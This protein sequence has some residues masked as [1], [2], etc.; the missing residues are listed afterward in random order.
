[1][2]IR[3]AGMLAVVVS[4]VGV[5]FGSSA[6]AVEPTWLTEDSFGTTALQESTLQAPLDTEKVAESLAE[7]EADHQD[8]ISTPGAILERENSTDLF[9]GLGA[10][11]AAALFLDRFRIN[12]Q[13]LTSLPSDPVV[14]AD[15]I[16]EVNTDSS[17]SI[18]PQGPRKASLV[19]SDA[20]LRNESNELLNNSLSV[21]S[22]RFVPQAALT[23]TEIP[24][25]S[26]GQVEF[27]EAGLRM[28][29]GVEAGDGTSGEILSS[30]PGEDDIV[31]Y[32]NT[33]KDTDTAV[34]AT[35][36]GVETFSVLRSEESPETLTFDYEMPEGATLSATDDGGAV[37]TDGEEE[38]LAQIFPPYAVDAQG[39]FVPVTLSVED[40]S[41]GLNVAH[42][43]ADLA[44]PILVD[45]VMH[46][47][48]WWTNGTSADYLGWTF[49]QQGTT[50]Y[51]GS[52]VCPPAVL[53]ADP[54]GGT[55][56][57]LYTSAQP[58]VTYPSGSMG[59]WAFTAPGGPS[60]SILAASIGSWRLRTGPATSGNPYAFF[61]LGNTGTNMVANTAGGGSNYGLTGSAND[62]KVLN[63]G[64]ATNANVTLPS[65][66]TNWRYN[67]LA[68]F[69][70]ELTD[71]EAPTINMTAP[72][73]WLKDNTAYSVTANAADPGL[74]LGWIQTAPFGGSW[75][76]Q[77]A[78]WCSGT[79]GAECPKTASHTMSFNT[80]T[81]TSG[82]N[83]MF[84]KA[85]DVLAGTGHETTVGYN[86]KV[87]KVAPTMATS[88]LLVDTSNPLVPASTVVEVDATDTH[89]G[90]DRAVLKVDGVV[91]GETDVPCETD[92]C[93]M[94][95]EKLEFDGTSLTSG[96]HNYQIIT[97]D[98]A[99]NPSTAKSGTF[100]LDNTSPVLN[101]SGTLKDRDDLPLFT[102]TASVSISAVDSGT[103]DTGVAMFEV[104]EDYGTPT[105]YNQSC[106][107]S[108]PSTASGSYTF[109][110]SVSG[111][112]PHELII[113]AFDKAG[114][115][116]DEAF[117][118]DVPAA[119][120]VSA[121]CPTGSSVSVQST[122]TV[123][124][125][126][127]VA[128][129]IGTDAAEVLAPADVA[130]DV[131]IEKVW[132]PTL[133]PAATGTTPA[134][135]DIEMIQT[136]VEGEMA[137]EVEGGFTIGESHC[138]VPNQTT[139]NSTE[140]VIVNN[141]SAVYANTATETD[142]VVRPTPNGTATIQRLRSSSAEDTF[143]W[144]LD[145]GPYESIVELNNGGIAVVNTNVPV[146]AEAVS[147]PNLLTDLSELSDSALQMEQ[148]NYNFQYA[149]AQTEYAVVSV[150]AP[151][152]SFSSTGVS[153]PTSLTK[154]GS[155][156][157]K[158]IVSSPPVTYPV[159]SVAQMSTPTAHVSVS[160]EGCI[161]ANR[162]CLYGT[163]RFKG[164]AWPFK[165]SGWQ[166][167]GVVGP[168]RP[169]QLKSAINRVQNGSG[170]VA[171]GTRLVDPAWGPSY[172]VGK[173]P[174]MCLTDGFSKWPTIP[175]AVSKNAY[176][177]NIQRNNRNCSR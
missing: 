38:P 167:V 147:D 116:S 58:G 132:D 69:A 149:E 42:L 163:K 76:P 177:L 68:A 11:S 64:L 74:G 114:N 34:A 98:K 109:D 15:E 35:L 28:G 131:A 8:A 101:T 60:T 67:R 48:D 52:K 9:S 164:M 40:D 59:Y 159:Y 63:V 93:A 29:L 95:D 118:V 168:G 105:V 166:D 155:N 115:S 73:G 24:G 7:F 82:T 137:T 56:A 79:Y 141:D 104:V 97:Y 31:F 140:A 81:L 146:A 66:S 19:V 39:S 172:W 23:E 160:V 44:Y 106:S 152:Q 72:T 88:G 143:E 113:R 157:L 175:D 3:I 169:A 80:S 138:L 25:S 110:K 61:A 117:H 123:K 108:C 30:S 99:G 156:K 89:S 20:P 86:I 103:G 57:G 85:M 47:R 33:A 70:V 142:T 21:E 43:N 139:A 136:E 158:L 87:D 126:L 173:S 94:V 14:E 51:V 151:P 112:G 77:W 133:E 148:S 27:P 107:P 91:N 41:V 22:G 154:A 37:I 83:W 170:A 5:L 162:I 129:E 145:L 121:I 130:E 45:P 4:F 100:V 90:I 92:G 119:P 174:K 125:G 6:F 55:G 71:N 2:K 111:S 54:C 18:D 161:W 124:S 16:L 10:G 12:L 165:D 62:T 17:I 78:G 120:P 53:P 127:D 1:M 122:G 135:T 153:V 84:A 134:D 150:I 144:S 49:N 176:M 102:T 128:T 171:S 26:A 65:G 50:N 75:T 36:G 13:A 46:V 32:P 96:S